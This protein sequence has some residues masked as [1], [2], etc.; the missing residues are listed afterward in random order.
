MKTKIS[1]LLLVFS[2]LSFGATKNITVDSLLDYVDSSSSEIKIHKLSEDIKDIQKSAYKMANFS[3]ARIE[4][5]YS[6]NLED[7]N[8]LAQNFN[9]KL[10]IGPFFISYNKNNLKNNTSEFASY[11]FSKN[12]KDFIV[13]K[14]S[15]ELSKLDISSKIDKINFNDMKYRNKEKAINL[16]TELLNL[17]EE[18][19]IKND[20]LDILKNQYKILKKS[21]ELGVL[22][23]IELDSGNIT[24]DNLEL[25]LK[26]IDKRI[27][28]IKNI[29]KNEYGIDT[30]DADFLPI[31]IGSL[32]I[33]KESIMQSKIDM[34]KLNSD[35]AETDLKY[36]RLNNS[37]PDV[38][39]SLYQKRALNDSASLY[40]DRDV[41]SENMLEIRFSKSLITPSIENDILR[42]NERIKEEEYKNTLLQIK[43]ARENKSIEM[44][45][46]K[47]ALEMLKK[48]AELDNKKYQIDLKLYELQNIS[49]IKLMES[50]NNF[51]KSALE[52]AKAV[53]DYNALILKNSLN[54]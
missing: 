37:L 43:T 17:I 25:D 23:K 20:S 41:E 31:D 48:K 51:M 52:H 5:G 21:Y 32:E 47:E 36:T 15:V 4:G 27:S 6:T 44:F 40:G 22:K 42:L 35:L 1:F 28:A 33:N 2:M 39:V 49:Y 26:I 14:N 8:R 7:G 53:N 19:K 50:F 10:A 24:M 13:S 18:Q 38:N 46:K 45:S 29:I 16:Y 54:K 34:A 11:G 9:F 12:L 30:Q 3:G